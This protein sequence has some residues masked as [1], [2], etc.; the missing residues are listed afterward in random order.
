MSRKA[1]CRRI[2]DR[3]VVRVLPGVFRIT[4]TPAST[5]SPRWRRRS[6]PETTPWCRT[7]PQR[8]RGGSRARASERSSSGC[9]RRGTAP[10]ADRRAPR[11]RDR[12]GRSRRAG[13]DPAHDSRPHTHRPL[14]ADGGRSRCSPRWRAL[15]RAKLCTP[16][17]LAVRV[18]A[19]RTSGRPGAGRLAALLA[20][21]AGPAL[22]SALEAKVWLLFVAAAYRFRSGSTGSRLPGGRYRLDFA[23]PEQQGRPRVRRLG[24]PRRASGVRSRSGTARRVRRCALAGAAR[25]LGRL[26]ARTGP[27]AMRWVRDCHSSADSCGS[28]EHGHPGQ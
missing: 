6:G 25:H 28:S 19:L 4:G 2:R 5:P 26:H 12:S 8:R 18:D 17:R 20:S 16:E 9:R 1:D 3:L 10:R 7:R 14:G 24:A 11:S 27:R 21:R 23:W 22:E 15:F 13:P